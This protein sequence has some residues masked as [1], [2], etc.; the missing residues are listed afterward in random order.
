[1]KQKQIIALVSATALVATALAGCGKTSEENT[2][3]TAVGE[4]EGTAKEDLPFSKYAEPVKVHLGGSM[5][6]NAKI[7]DG[8]S[9]EDNSYTRLLKKDL[10]IDVVY[11]W[12][13][14]SSDFEEKMNLCIGSGAIP[15]LMNVN[16]TQY[17]ALLKYDMIQPL[18]QYFDDYASDTLKGYVES[19]GD[20]LKECITNDKGGRRNERNVDSSGLA[21]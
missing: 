15:D 10:N 20:K 9:Y 17:R 13:A 8:M 16:A 18:D 6:P 11:D 1:M 19:G 5:N 7:P 14:S 4:A 2:Q 12:V 3:K 21:G